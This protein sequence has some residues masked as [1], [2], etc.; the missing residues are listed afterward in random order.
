MRTLRWMMAAV[1][2]WMMV[3]GV[4]AFGQDV[5][6]TVCRPGYPARAKVFFN[7]ALAEFQ[8][9]NPS[10]KFK[11]VDADW[12]TF[13]SR[14]M[15]WVAGQQE[16]DIYVSPLQQ[17]VDLAELGAYL[18]LDKYID[19]ALKEDIP[20]S[21]WWDMSRYSGGKGKFLSVAAT[22][23]TYALWYNKKILSQAGL[24]RPPKTWDELVQFGKQIV[25]RTKIPAIGMNA[26]RPFDTTQLLF[27]M[28]YFSGTNQPF[29]DARGR[30][31]INSPDAVKAVQFWVDLYKKHKITNSSPE[32]TSKGD[33]RLLF[34]Q[35]KLA[36]H[37]DTPVMLPV[38]AK[39]SDLSSPETSNFLI[40][41]PFQ[42]SL[43]GRQ[44]MSSTDAQQWVISA[45]TKH[46]DLAWKVLRYLLEPRWQNEQDRIQG[47]APF[48]KSILKTM[49]IDHAWIMKP[50]A[51]EVGNGIPFSPLVPRSGQVLQV[52][53]KYLV[54]ALLER[55]TVKD[56]LDRAAAEVNKLA[57][58]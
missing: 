20:E 21:L 4:A 15:V 33:L 39:I 9:T 38:L 10:V 23:S 44:A 22:A 47:G 42:P 55:A 29:V 53:N 17:F 3:G 52:L 50:N 32:Q 43:S 27:G 48:R 19:P 2:C 31:L 58:F 34:Q 13:Q 5:E 35:G 54:E 18:P 25:D 16:P 49:K 7:K 57:G 6:L 14:I 51:E 40:G 30:A 45:H 37:V 12:E 24:T 41:G 46:P 56:A 8:K 36:M 26:S 1:V 11:I 28:L